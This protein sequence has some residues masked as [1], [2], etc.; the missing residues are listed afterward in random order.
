MKKHQIPMI[1]GVVAIFLPSLLHGEEMIDRLRELFKDKKP[2]TI[3]GC[4]DVRELKYPG[5]KFWHVMD[6]T[7]SG[8]GQ[9]V[10][11]RFWGVFRIYP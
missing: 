11:P 8:K 9:L 2:V 10:T 1:L 5:Q 4:E 6:M 7:V 3:G